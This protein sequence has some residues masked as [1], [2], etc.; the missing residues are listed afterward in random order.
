MPTRR[1]ARFS[2]T[3]LLFACLGVQLVSSA[4]PGRAE[5]QPTE[6]PPLD[7][8]IDLQ[9]FQPAIGPRGFLTLDSATVPAHKLFGLSLYTNYQVS[10]FALSTDLGNGESRDVEVIKSQGTSTLTGGV[11]LFDRVQLG[12]AL[13]VTWYMDGQ[14]FSPAGVPAGESLRGGGLGD[15]RVEA[16]G[17]ISTWRPS[18]DRADALSLA[19]VVGFTAPTGNEQKFQGDKGA[20]VRLKL[21][22]EFRAGD[23]RAG[24]MVGGILRTK[25][26]RLFAAEVG[27]QLM[28]ALATEYSVQ[29]QV[30]LVAEVFG[31]NDF[32]GWVDASPMEAALALRVAIT[33]MFSATL[34]G[35]LGV[36]KG[37]GAPKARALL[38]LNWSPDFRDRDRDGV[39]DI[40]DRCPEE[41]E[42][43]DGFRDS[44]GC[45]EEDNDG[46]GL[47]DAQDKCVNSAEDLD[48]FED[49]DGCPEVDN[50]KDGM[51]DLNDPC[52][53]AAEDGKGKRPKDGCPSS[54]EDSDGDGVVDAKDKCADEPEDRD[55]F[56]DYDGCPDSDND[57][58]GIP[59]GYDG[60][61][62]A[63]ED[64]D[65]FEDADGCPDPD[66][67]H[68][69]FLDGQDKC[70][71]K[72]ETLNGNKDD[73]GCPDPGAEV[74]RLVDDKIEVRERIA[75][76]ER[77]G[78]VTLSP[79]GATITKLVSLL[80]KGHPELDPVRVE[81]T[82]DNATEAATQS[83]AD[84]VKAALVGHGVPE[85]RIKAVGKGGGSSKIEFVVES[86]I[87]LKKA[88]GAATPA[89]PA[90]E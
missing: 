25:E 30:S 12:F 54:A 76:V 52:P 62:S 74:V 23:L 33:S 57:D 17:L 89:A 77:A 34:G 51:P 26:S 18:E 59:D 16:K 13:P 24:G 37:I 45:A 53:N 68:D 4:F 49:E 50:D 86:V 41:R 67:D 70:P 31:R 8:S 81:V 6:T 65:G 66:N 79:A 35:G 47:L 22:A 28:F 56:Q 39:P 42:D 85:R 10:P 80:L 20:T 15:L 83:R 61:P 82:A 43:R 72:A 14:R 55:G 11:G 63:A 19:G 1:V 75:F 38:G 40:D 88:S 60:C 48:Q 3:F 29:K 7:Q 87:D 64:Q 78:A 73:D 32:S 71:Q 36:I 44:D 84:A 46:D 69:G 58:D 90:G 9:L 27:H 2:S 21:L 5:A